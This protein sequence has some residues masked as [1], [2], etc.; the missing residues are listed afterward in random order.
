MNEDHLINI[1]NHLIRAH[2]KIG[3]LYMLAA[4]ISCLELHY[5][6]KVT[7][8]KFTWPLLFILGFILSTFQ[9]FYYLGLY[10]AFYVLTHFWEHGSVYTWTLAIFKD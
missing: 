1:L 7:W 10:N 5:H 6:E 3:L 9:L 4:I 8:F 2:D